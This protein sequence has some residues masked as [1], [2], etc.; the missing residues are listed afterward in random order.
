[1]TGSP[2]QPAARPNSLFERG[3]IVDVV[4]GA[5]SY[6]G[7]SWF[8][9]RLREPFTGTTVRTIPGTLGIFRH[10]FRSSDA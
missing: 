3:V 8:P 7:L 6:A 10:G 9:A 4:A 5:S 2:S 1:M